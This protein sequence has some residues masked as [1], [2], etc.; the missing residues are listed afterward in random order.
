MSS[1]RFPPP[2][3]PVWATHQQLPPQQQLPQQQLPPQPQQQLQQQQQQHYPAYPAAR[4]PQLQEQHIQQGLA[5]HQPVQPYLQQPTWE[6]PSQQ[7][8]GQQQP[9]EPTQWQQ[10]P[11]Q[12][13]QQRLQQQ[14]LQQQLLQQQQLQQQQLQQQQLQQQQRQQQ[15]LQQQQLYQQQQQQRMRDDRLKQHEQQLQQQPQAGPPPNPPLQSLP[16]QQQQQQQLSFQQSQAMQ[17]TEG[18]PTQR[19][20]AS[21]ASGLPAAG[22]GAPSGAPVPLAFPQAQARSAA[23]AAAGEAVGAAQTQA[24]AAAAERQ[25]GSLQQQ[26]QQP[27]RQS[28]RP[29]QPPLQPVLPQQPQQPQQQQALPAPQLQVAP[30]QQQLYARQQ[31]EPQPTQQL[32]QQN[33]VAPHQPYQYQQGQP[34]SLIGQLQQQQQ[35]YAEDA[36]LPQQHPAQQQ[37]S[38]PKRG[39]AQDP[40][41]QQRQ[42][43]QQQG[44]Q[45]Q[46]LLPQQQQL[47]Q[48]HLQQQQLQQQQLQQQQLQQQQ[49]QQQLQ[50]Q[51]LQQQQQQPQQQQQ[52]Q[53]QPQQQQQHL[54]PHHRMPSLV[55]VGTGSFSSSGSVNGV[56]AFDAKAE[57]QQR[58]QQQQQQQQVGTSEMPALQPLARP[59][60]NRIDPAHIP[61]PEWNDQITNACGKRI[62]TDKPGASP[63]SPA[64]LYTAIDKGCCSCR[65]MRSTLNQVP[66][67]SHSLELSRLPFALVV[68]P[69]A[70]QPPT[71]EPV[72]LVDLRPS[73]RQADLST[74][75]AV[76]AAAAA[77]GG[78]SKG[79]G[80]AAADCFAGY[81]EVEDSEAEED[82]GSSGTSTRS[83]SS[84][85]AAA[86]AANSEGIVRCSSCQGYI[87][88]FMA[89]ASNST[90]CV[91]NLC[92]ASFELPAFYLALLD[93]YRSGWR[94]AGGGAA[95]AAGREDRH[96]SSQRLE[97]WRGSVDFVAPPAFAA[98]SKLSQL[99][100]KRK[101]QLRWLRR[102]REEAARQQ[103]LRHQQHQHMEEQQQHQQHLDSTQLPGMQQQQ[104]FA[105]QQQQQQQ[106]QQQL[107][108]Q[109]GW[110]SRVPQPP[111]DAAAQPPSVP[112]QPSSS[113]SS[114]SSSS[115]SRMRPCVV[116][117]VDASASSLTSGLGEAFAAG[118]QEVLQEVYLQVDVCLMLVADRIYFLLNRADDGGPRQQQQQ[119]QQQQQGLELLV[120]NDIGDP[121]LPAPV[122]RLFF[123]PEDREQAGSGRFFACSERQRL[124][125]LCV[126][127]QLLEAAA[128]L[129]SALDKCV[130]V[131]QTS[132]ANAALKVAVDLVAERSAGGMVEMFYSSLPDVGLG[133]LTRSTNAAQERGKTTEIHQQDFYN[134]VIT[135]C[136]AS[137]VCVD[138]FACPPANMT[139]ELQSLGFPAQQTGGDIRFVPGFSGARD[140][141]WVAAEIRRIFTSCFYFDV[142]FKLRPSKGLAVD[143]I[144]VAFSGARSLVDQGTFR[145]P[146][147]SQ[148]STLLFQLKHTEQLETQKHVYLQ[149]VCA[150]TPMHPSKIVPN[151]RLLRV[152]SLSL[153]L[154]FSLAS[155]F[156][157]AEVDAMAFFMARS[158]AKMELHQEPDWREKT[159]KHLVEILSAYRANCASASSEGQLILPDSL[160]LLPVY[161]QALFK[162]AAFRQST[163]DPQVRLHQLLQFLRMS[164]VEFSTHL[165]PRLCL[166]HKSYIQPMSARERK[167]LERLGEYSGVGDLVWMP[168]SL[169][170]SGTNILSDGVYLCEAGAYMMLYIGQHVKREHIID[171]FGCD[172]K[173]DERSAAELRL[174]TAEGSA[175]ARVRRVVEQIRFEKFGAPFIPLRIVAPKS[176][177]ETRLLTH[178]IE[179]PL[180]GDGSYVDFLCDLH[181]RVHA[182]MDEA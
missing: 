146:R 81:F 65:F 153:P 9:K 96:L 177:D 43:Q 38:Q 47:L 169:P 173:L 19:L 25:F 93:E 33:Q 17:G 85:K 45:Q 3:P 117:V 174:Q 87:S 11:E 137:C 48:Q 125:R 84:S 180:S 80:E 99:Q 130:A 142:E 112:G 109:S 6:Q 159:I 145:L 89:W 29:Q 128:M 88:P 36:R 181:K 61:R 166:L 67:F 83:S 46:Q 90:H 91:C 37:P 56:K 75:P 147:L 168:L 31:L 140:R 63:P 24:T 10:H 139:L 123:S 100:A 77:A 178:L 50:Q 73:S 165:Y 62:E 136:F 68:S 160:K 39:P 151:R 44:L 79:E 127:A 60:N 167:A 171:L 114:S 58:Q 172:A 121:F 7:L 51:Q 131:S 1:E 101:R 126:C 4:A 182:L 8:T 49:L 129:P 69:F 111:S 124:A 78:G 164:I 12:Q 2:G 23:S 156:R 70:A 35:Q 135:T 72:P 157:Y 120:V 74:P 122:E 14:Q 22:L 162:H 42:L 32:L 21:S 15:Q 115:T 134:A 143:R 92:G 13:P 144:L 133:A 179:D 102:L 176:S 18:P 53:Q 170:A 82:E 175:G 30:T 20:P 57:Q 86:A 141:E 149:S 66:A 103:L 150:Y 94:A 71:E 34:P 104:Q 138:V 64:G 105:Q 54:Q 155:L 116:F 119:Q 148:Q 41:Q 152:H 161:L 26:Q 40:S 28:V 95:A 106:M 118:L 163:V 59:L 76:A 52:S 97:L 158:S 107:L 55:G 113:S 27:Q 154:T 16:Q 98:V 132:A 5:T 110:G 108:Q